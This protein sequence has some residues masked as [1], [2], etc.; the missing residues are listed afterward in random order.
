MSNNKCIVCDEK[1]KGKK[2]CV[3]CKMLICD[4]CINN[5]NEM[6]YLGY[7]WMTINHTCDKCKK[8]VCDNCII[9]CCECANL[10][11]DFSIYCKKCDPG[12]ITDVQCEYHKWTVCNKHK[13]VCGV[14]RA[15][16]NYSGKYEI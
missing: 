2:K 5:E 1:S 7:E 13:K 8:N 3:I 14:C 4:N 6:C 16:K 9:A 12:N 15:N 10:G 11:D